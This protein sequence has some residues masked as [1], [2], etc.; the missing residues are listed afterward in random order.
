MTTASAKPRARFRRAVAIS[1]RWLHI[2]LSM[3]SFALVL[4]F[5]VTG[6]TLNHPDWFANRERTEQ[7][8]G[9]ASR[10][11]LGPA[12]A[13]QADRLGLVEMLRAREHVHGAV[14]D[15][16][17]EDAQISISFR[18]PGYTADAFIDRD[19]GRYDL[20]EVRNGFVAVLNDLHKGRDTGKAWSLIID[21]SAVMLVLVSITGLVLI[22]FVYKR[23][24]SGLLLAALAAAGASAVWLLFIK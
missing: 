10:A 3:A 23:R 8:H 21:L 15:F 5:A 11:L 12:G 7:R 16:R 18:A 22:W 20:T 9:I 24:T 14:S 13:E 6:L 19:S 1:A 2:Y 4:F 17:T